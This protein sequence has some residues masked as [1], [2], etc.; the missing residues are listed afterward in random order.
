VAKIATYSHNT[1]DS[2]SSLRQR[3]PGAKLDA[4]QCFSGLPRHPLV[5]S[6]TPRNDVFVNCYKS[7]YDIIPPCFNIYE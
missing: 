5:N 7:K 1:S 4:I 3:A 2:E 6:R